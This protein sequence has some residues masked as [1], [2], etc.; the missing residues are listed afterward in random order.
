VESDV[1]RQRPDRGPRLLVGEAERTVPCLQLRDSRD[2]R[3]RER[4]VLETKLH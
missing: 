4:I 1:P 2:E 3:L